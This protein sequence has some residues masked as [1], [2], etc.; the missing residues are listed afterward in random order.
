M[1]FS[2]ACKGITTVLAILLMAS[3]RAFTVDKIG[4]KSVALA[5]R[6][7]RPVASSFRSYSR[8][9]PTAFASVD[10]KNFELS[11]RLDG[12]DRPTVWHEFSPLAVDYGAINLGQGFPDWEPPDF[13]ISAMKRAVDPIYQRHA[14]QYARSAA[15]MPLA[16]VL[17]DIYTKRWKWDPKI[18][19][20]TQI[21]TGVG[22]TNVLYCALQGLLNPGDQVILI[23][24]AFDIYS[25]Q[26]RMAGG[27]PVYVPLRPFLGPHDGNTSNEAFRLDLNELEAAITDK[28]KVLLINTPHNPTGKMFT[29]TELQ[30]IAKIVRKHP[31]ITI[32]S[33]EVYEHITFERKHISIAIYN[34]EQTLTIS[35]AG[36]TFSATGWKVGWAVGPKHLVKAVSAVQQWVNFS[37]PTPNQD[38]IAQCLLRAEQP[39][40]DLRAGIQ[41]PS[42]YQYLSTQYRE[43]RTILASALNAANMTPIIPPGGFFIMA[44]TSSVGFPYHTY[45]TQETAA[46][47]VKPMP[48][49]WALSRWL[50]E[51]VGVTAIPP[52][53]FYSKEN[54]DLAANL[55]RFAFCKSDET[56]V[57]AFTRFGTYFGTIR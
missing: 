15:H 29:A 39:Y 37:V 11:H 47:P 53:A 38:A 9:T 13:A 35:S 36:K 57:E 17:A 34:P 12:L 33:D 52:S 6:R 46:M 48:R 24:P 8:T 50:T 28:T 2:S 16:T 19:P 54:V 18:D 30:N 40:R 20:E 56:L 44:E 49:D 14:N 22:T 45:Q 27:V 32:I 10:D 23:E 31:R 42:Y 1:D 43:K 51:E 7:R 5:K 26:V 41:Y 4:S 25:S 55:L 3:T 21:A